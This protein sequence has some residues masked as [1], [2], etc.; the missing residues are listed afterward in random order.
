MA[1]LSSQ[2]AVDRQSFDGRPIAAI[3]DVR[4]PELSCRKLPVIL[5]HSLPLKALNTFVS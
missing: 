1:D 2:A 3:A 4:S 5:S